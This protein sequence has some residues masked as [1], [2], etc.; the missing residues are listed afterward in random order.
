M[1]QRNLKLHS[2]GLLQNKEYLYIHN[3]VL[4]FF[5]SKAYIPLIRFFF[6]VY[7]FHCGGNQFFTRLNLSY[8]ISLFFCPILHRVCLL[9]G[10]SCHK[11]FIKIMCNSRIQKHRPSKCVS[12]LQMNFH[13][14]WFS[15]ITSIFGTSI[16]TNIYSIT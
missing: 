7:L 11:R 10:I 1:F 16:V 4:F 15:I 12:T 3:N 14:G 8:K 2:V 9:V 6:K 13:A 5:M